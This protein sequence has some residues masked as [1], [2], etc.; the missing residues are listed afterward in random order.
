MKAV[1]FLC[2][3]LLAVTSV[4]LAINAATTPA[5]AATILRNYVSWTVPK[6]VHHIRL[7]ETNPDGSAVINQVIAVSPGQKFVVQA[8]AD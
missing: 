4:E 7:L 2:L 1:C 6:T 5:S 3:A 8:I